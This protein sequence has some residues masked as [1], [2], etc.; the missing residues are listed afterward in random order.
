METKIVKK[1]VAPKGNKA[2]EAIKELDT[3][4]KA[5]VENIKNPPEA[6]P[7]AEQQLAKLESGGKKVFK[8][9]VKKVVKVE[10]GFERNDFK[11]GLAFV[12]E[13]KKLGCEVKQVATG[14]K[15]IVQEPKLFFNGKA[16]CMITPRAGCRFGQIGLDVSRRIHNDEEQKELLDAIKVDIE[17]IKNIP[18]VK[19]VPKEKKVVVKKAGK[20]KSPKSFIEFAESMESRIADLDKGHNAIKLP[21]GLSIT[22]PELKVW[23]E[24]HGFEL[25]TEEAIVV[26]HK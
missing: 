18:V 12:A 21:K 26:V 7:N 5:C 2:V 14:R 16:V 20:V 3:R 11:A 10:P 1:G 8:E 25:N 22:N 19:K 13:C 23:A 15:D 17:R 24:E 9:K 4:R 6:K